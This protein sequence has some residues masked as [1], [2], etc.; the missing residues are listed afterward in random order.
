M[1]LIM[2][3]YMGQTVKINAKD[4]RYVIGSQYENAAI[5]VALSLHD[6]IAMAW[7]HFAGAV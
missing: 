6:L 5:P 1:S 3:Q 4:A 2:S 7:T